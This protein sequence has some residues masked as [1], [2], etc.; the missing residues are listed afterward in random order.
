[1]LFFVLNGHIL[2]S[3]KHPSILGDCVDS[4]P[5]ICGEEMFPLQFSQKNINENGSPL[6]QLEKTNNK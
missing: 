6:R 5:P 2:L 3:R 4:N 1:M